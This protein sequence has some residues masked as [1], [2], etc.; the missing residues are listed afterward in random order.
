MA[1]RDFQV[2]YAQ[3][4]LG[5]A[6]ALIQPLF[7]VAVLYLVFSRALKADTAGIPFLSYTLSGLVFWGFFNYN[8]GQGATALIQ[9]RSMLQKIYFPRILLVLSKSLVASIDLLFIL[10]IFGIIA[11][12][13]IQLGA[14]NLLGFFS[15]LILSFLASQG[16]ALWIAALSI[17]FRDLQQIIPF[18][19]QILFFLSPIAYSTSLWSDSM[20]ST[21]HWTLY[22]NPMFGI[23]ENWRNSLFAI[24]PLL[25]SSGLLLGSAVCLTLFIS[26]WLFF[27][28]SESKMADLL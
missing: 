28:K 16:L 2:R 12:K 20:S 21:Y 14:L 10:V 26:G 23:L 1:R 22:L 13:D 6:W 17:R 5:A 7:S 18:L 27:Q 19:S 15:S 3:T 9:A 4:I 8:L 25:G 24:E 11:H